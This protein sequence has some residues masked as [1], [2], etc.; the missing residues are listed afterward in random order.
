MT[1]T[2][3]LNYTMPV[4][5]D[6][7]AYRHRRERQLRVEKS[8]YVFDCAAVYAAFTQTYADARALLGASL[9]YNGDGQPLVRA[10]VRPQPHDKVYIESAQNV[11]PLWVWAFYGEPRF[12]G[13]EIGFKFGKK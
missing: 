2:L 11:D 9:T 7:R 4:P 8:R 3:D 12:V 6:R 13:G 1:A 10:G 5:C